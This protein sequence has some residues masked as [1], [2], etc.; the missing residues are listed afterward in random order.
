MNEIYPGLWM[1]SEPI[2][3]VEY[4]DKF[5]IIV[6]AAAGIKPQHKKFPN[7]TLFYVPLL[8]IRGENPE[9]GTFERAEQ[10][11]IWLAKEVKEGKQVLVTCAS[12]INRSG[13]IVA[14][15]LRL[16]TGW[17]GIKCVEEV[18]NKRVFAFTNEDFANFVS[19]LLSCEALD[20]TKY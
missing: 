10:M 15:T 2:A 16:L 7:K 9:P 3:P 17:P 11:A 13:L 4:Y 12:G 1:G 5:D 20:E 6:Y 8:D 18:R 19:S 14:L